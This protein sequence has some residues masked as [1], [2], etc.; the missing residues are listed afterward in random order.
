MRLPVFKSLPHI[1]RSHQVCALTRQIIVDITC[2]IRKVRGRGERSSIVR[3]EERKEGT[4]QKIDTSGKSRLSPSETGENRKTVRI[5][6]TGSRGWNIINF[7]EN[8]IFRQRK[9]CFTLPIQ[10]YFSIREFAS[11]I[12]II[13]KGFLCSDRADRSSRKHR[14]EKYHETTIIHISIGRQF[15]SAELSVRHP[16]YAVQRPSQR[17]R[18]IM[19]R[20]RA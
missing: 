10:V 12:F 5:L 9:K 8:K 18:R 20:Q 7:E 4:C 19:A 6:L 1:A 11:R 17:R 2:T 14:S 15:T 3:G 16:G 13:N